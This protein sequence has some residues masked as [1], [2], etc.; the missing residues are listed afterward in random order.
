MAVV[1][2]L[3]TRVQQCLAGPRALRARLVAVVWCGS[4]PLP[5]PQCPQLQTSV[6]GSIS[7]GVQTTTQMPFKIHILA[8]AFLVTARCVLEHRRTWAAQHL[9]AG[10]TQMASIIIITALQPELQCTSFNICLYKPRPISAGWILNCGATA[11]ISAV[12]Y[13]SR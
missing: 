4:R 8:H 3:T 10:D 5:S 2:Q 11:Q 1:L 12:F 6:L 13:S 9:L 7:C